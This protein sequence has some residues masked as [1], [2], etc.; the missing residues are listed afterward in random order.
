MQIY[1]K[2]AAA[3]QPHG[4]IVRGGFAP[5]PADRQRDELPDTARS[6]VLIGNAGDAMWQAFAAQRARDADPLDAW[7][8]RVVLPIAGA[9][10]AEAVFPWSRPYRPFQQWAMRA[11]AVSPSPLGILI[12][13]EHGLWHAY[14]AAL[15]FRDAIDLPPRAER[16]SPCESCADKPCLSAC[17]VGAFQEDA[18][19]VSACAAFLS[20]PTGRATCRTDGCAARAACPVGTPYPPAQIRFHMAAFYASRPPI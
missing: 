9:F 2:L 8:E 5:S 7:T 10:A 16:A 13:P 17:P 20:G 14:R 11:E 15:V 1:E 12:H 4:L 6:V 18:Y 3:L 19:D